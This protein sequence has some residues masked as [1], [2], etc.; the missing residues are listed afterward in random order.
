MIRLTQTLFKLYINLYFNL[1]CLIKVDVFNTTIVTGKTLLSSCV[2][3]AF[4]LPFGVLSYE[5]YVFT[6]MA[7]LGYV[8]AVLGVIIYVGFINSEYE[9]AVVVNECNQCACNDRL[10]KYCYSLNQ[11]NS[12]VKYYRLLGVLNLKI[13]H[14]GDL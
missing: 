11:A 8:I 4:M 1:K 5:P 2:V 13:R 10:V 7:Y 6:F 9:Y 12:V 3:A 14:I